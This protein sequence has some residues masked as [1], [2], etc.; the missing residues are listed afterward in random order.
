MGAYHSSELP[1]L[2]GTYGDFRGPGSK[3]EKSTSEVMQ[4]FYLAFA[5]D[6]ENGPAKLGWPKYAEGK[7]E[8]FGE[9]LNGKEYTHRYVPKEEIEYVCKDYGYGM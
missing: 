3:F 6:P 5:R 8:V 2:F 9:V 7:I 4:D 1:M